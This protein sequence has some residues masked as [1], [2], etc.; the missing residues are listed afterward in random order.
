[1][2]QLILRS[3]YAL[4]LTALAVF[5][6]GFTPQATTPTD[7]PA[8][9]EDHDHADDHDHDQLSPP[10]D[11]SPADEAV[12]DQAEEDVES[13]A[14]EAAGDAPA[15]AADRVVTGDWPMWG[16]TTDRNM[17]NQT[18]HVNIDEFDP[19]SGTKI[20]WT[21]Q[22]G[23]QTYGN[24]TVSGGKI[25]VGTNNGA[26][27]RPQHEGDKG[28]VLCFEEKTGEF[29]WQLTRDKLGTGRVN[30]WPEQG[31]C[32]SAAVEENRVYVVTNRC[33]L[34][35]LDTEGFRDGVNNG[36]Y[37][38]EEDTDEEDA[39]IIW[40]LD[41]MEE[42][43]VFPHNLATA[44]PVIHG[45]YVYVLTSNGV[46]EAHL[47]V[48]SPR[49]PSFICVHKMTGELVW[50]DNSPFDEILHGQW[51][52]PAIGEVNGQVQVYM[53]GGDGWLYTFD[54]VSGEL[55]WKFDCNPKDSVYQLGGR[56]TRNEIISTP[57]FLDN[58]VLVAVGQDPEHGEGV[59]HMYRVDAT[60]T[61]D[62]SPVLEDDDDE[63]GKGVPN[64][65]SAQIWHYG[66]EDTDGSITGK[67]GPRSFVF[68][69]T[70]STPA[71]HDG[72]VYAPD[73]SGYVHCIDFETGERQWEA[74]LLAAIWGSPMVVDGKVLIGDEDG[75]L[76]I[77]ATG[78]EEKLL[79]ELTF[80]SSLYSTPVIA[81]GVMYISDRSRLY[82][83]DID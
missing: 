55:I 11:E 29:L 68:R 43:A 17:I 15:E 32:S 1:M 8:P 67:T 48:P 22:L 57:V 83:I 75:D 63:T 46:D 41:M 4:C 80:P 7:T 21:A 62:V 37:Q 12:D 13:A 64:P 56:G 38:D 77:F 61:G 66:G 45:D 51:A 30:D 79:R 28:V 18:T 78:R 31:I 47:E 26:Q 36:P 35:C 58:S 40:V 50:E 72:L 73:F 34:M 59:G 65:N 6:A 69:R 82:A 20:L 14:A 54:G 49:S 24:P 9:V 71:V 10:A 3:G 74:D 27:Y 53:P 44:S 76:S 25:F 33:E 16:G 19:R 60:K 70:I 81:N 23:S 42:L 2:D 5:M 52:S 39:D